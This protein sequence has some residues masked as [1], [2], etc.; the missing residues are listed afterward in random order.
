MQDPVGDRIDFDPSA[1][2][3]VGVY[4]TSGIFLLIA[5]G[6]GF[7]EGWVASLLILLI[8]SP[9]I[10]AVAGLAGM[11]GRVIIDFPSK[12]VRIETGRR[13]RPVTR[14]VP[15]SAF[16]HLELSAMANG[17]GD[18]HTFCSLVEASGPKH[19]LFAGST[20]IDV[21]IDRVNRL[22]T[23]MGLPVE[24]DPLL[25]TYRRYYHRRQGWRRRLG[26]GFIA[27]A[28][29]LALVALY[30]TLCWSGLPLPWADQIA[31]FRFGKSGQNTAWTLVGLSAFFAL[32]F[33][34]LG[35]Y[36]LV[37]KD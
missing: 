5:F 11:Y 27:V 1:D 29:G 32:L 4:V 21:V 20:E 33:G 6:F 2:L 3:I 37:R 12:T 18:S 9:L 28:V 8:F 36:K 35:W 24:H 22:A 23:R 15:F 10:Y 16:S 17:D 34:F 31:R 14:T 25:G 7:K 19:R 26:I 30:G 13:K